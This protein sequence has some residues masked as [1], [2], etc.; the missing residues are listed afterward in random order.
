MTIQ[1]FEIVSQIQQFVTRV[2]YLEVG[3]S[4]VHFL[5]S[6]KAKPAPAPAVVSAGTIEDNRHAS[7]KA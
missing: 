7:N 3:E 1:I 4:A 6:L 5:N 2:A